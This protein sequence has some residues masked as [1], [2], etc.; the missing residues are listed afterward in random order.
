MRF[1][2][3]SSS[4]LRMSVGGPGRPPSQPE[5]RGTLRKREQKRGGDRHKSKWAEVSVSEWQTSAARKTTENLHFA[6]R[7]CVNAQHVPLG[8][9]RDP[10]QP[11]FVRGGI[12][13]HGRL[14]PIPHGVAR[15]GSRV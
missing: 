2:A 11:L 9:R 4:V 8:G 6:V 7:R 10:G 1:A 15:D 13:G 3:R 14:G 12:A 5:G